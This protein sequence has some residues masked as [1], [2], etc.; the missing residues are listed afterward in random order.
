MKIK[1]KKLDKI[2]EKEKVYNTVS[3][4]KSRFFVKS[5]DLRKNKYN[6]KFKPKNL[7]LEDYDNDAWFKEKEYDEEVLD[8][9]PLLESDEEEVKEGKKYEEKVKEVLK[10]S[11]PNKY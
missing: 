11:T 4:L 8:D 9:M 1:Q 5:S 10:I 2:K 7:K 6:K 3:E